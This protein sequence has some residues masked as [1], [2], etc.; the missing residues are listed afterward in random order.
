MAKAISLCIKK[1]VLTRKLWISRE[2]GKQYRQIQKRFSD[3]CNGRCAIGVIMSY[4]GWSGKD[5][6]AEN[7]WAL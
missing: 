1:R 3:G 2:Y 6:S 5:D 4:F 7:Y